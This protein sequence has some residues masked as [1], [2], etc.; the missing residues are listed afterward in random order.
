VQ[1]LAHP[2]TWPVGVCVCACVRECMF[3]VL[4]IFYVFLCVVGVCV[5]CPFHTFWVV[6][7][8][9]VTGLTSVYVCVCVCMFV[10]VCMF[11]CLQTCIFVYFYIF[12][13]VYLYICIF[14][15]VVR[16]CVSPP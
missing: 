13:F 7:W 4:C 14:V 9:A 8:S 2:R 10:I 5:F 12:I 15:G 3:V 16:V 6:L 11:V 1:A